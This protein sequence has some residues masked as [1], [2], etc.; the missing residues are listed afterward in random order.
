M[1]EVYSPGVMVGDMRVNIMMIRNRGWEYSYGQTIGDM[2]ANGSMGNNM[3]LVSIIHLKVNPRRVS[4]K[5]G[6]EL[7]G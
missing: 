6:R 7:D 4:G 1:E 2:M 5:M 3:A